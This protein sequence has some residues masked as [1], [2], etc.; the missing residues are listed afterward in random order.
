[1]VK[2]VNLWVLLAAVGEREAL[3]TEVSPPSTP[4]CNAWETFTEEDN[5][6]SLKD[7]CSSFPFP[8]ISGKLS[9]FHFRLCNEMQS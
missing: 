7:I 6:R 1:M 9:E 5:F 4:I 3:Q 8:R 2:I